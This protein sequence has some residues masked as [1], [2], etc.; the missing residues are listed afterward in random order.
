MPSS[1]IRVPSKADFKNAQSPIIAVFLGI[2]TFPTKLA[3][4]A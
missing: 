3:V 1:I 4:S 2:D